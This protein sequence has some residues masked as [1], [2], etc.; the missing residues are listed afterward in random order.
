MTSRVFGCSA[1]DRLKERR[2]AFAVVSHTGDVMWIPQAIFK[3]SCVIDI[4]Y[5]PF[6][7]QVRRVYQCR[8][9]YLGDPGLALKCVPGIALKC[10]PRMAL[11]EVPGRLF[12]CACVLK[13]IQAVAVAIRL[14]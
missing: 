3:S 8:Y 2:K 1:D 9:F 4:T 14:R 13:H 10:V 11:N 7:K 12:E 6:D 5:F